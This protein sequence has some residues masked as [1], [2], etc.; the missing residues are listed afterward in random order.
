[1]ATH[2]GSGYGDDRTGV[3]RMRQCRLASRA[4]PEFTGPSP[5]ATDTPNNGDSEAPAADTAVVQEALRTAAGAA[6]NGRA[7]DFDTESLNGQRVFGIKVASNGNEIKVL[8]DESGRQVLSQRQSDGPSDDVAEAD[9]ARIDAGRALQAATDQ[10]T[11]VGVSAMEIDTNRDGIV[12][13]QVELVRGDGSHIELDV[14][15]Q[16][17]SVI[18]T[19]QG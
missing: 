6:P 18:A 5:A 2:C 11:N 14:D 16:N 8:V 17:G 4:H 19:G 12:I 10:E 15:T 3:G 1:M 7:F 13:W 9:T